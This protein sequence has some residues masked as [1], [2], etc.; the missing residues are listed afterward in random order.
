MKRLLVFALAVC[1]VAALAPIKFAERSVAIPN[2]YI[3][4]LKKDADVDGAIQKLKAFTVDAEYGWVMRGLKAFVVSVDR[5]NLNFIRSLSEVAH[6]EQ[7]SIGSIDQSI[8]S[9]GLDR[10]DQRDLPL[11]NQFVPEGDGA[12]TNIFVVDTGIFFDHNDFEGR[13]ELFLD[14]IGGSNPGGDC[15][16]HGSH[17]AGTVGGKQYGVAKQTKLWSVR[18]F[19]CTGSGSASNAAYAIEYIGDHGA[20]PGALSMSASYVNSQIVDDA[21]DYVID[22]DFAFATSSGNDNRDACFK[23]PQ[24]NRRTISVGATDSSDRRASF[25]NFGPCQD[26]WAPGV[27]IVSCD[28]TNP[29][30][31]SVK[32]GT[33]MACPHVAGVAA[34]KLGIKGDLTA[35]EVKTAILSDASVDRVSDAKEAENTPNLLLYSSA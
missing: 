31:S 28:N 33:S 12:G 7:D 24:R 34:I 13:A 3:V 21:A 35:D 16:G 27:S 29:N 4:S 9:W 14:V 32:S 22:R 25:S 18:V 6:I 8:A 19:S 10:T 23:S 20:K 2:K 17:C 1:S 30:G 11:D 15:H 5:A 26:I